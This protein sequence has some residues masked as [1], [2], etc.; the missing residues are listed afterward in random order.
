[1]TTFRT[2]ITAD[3][4][5]RPSPIAYQHKIL[6]LG[7]C[8]AENIGAKLANLYFQQCLN[9]FGISYNPASIAQNLRRLA[10]NRIFEPSELFEEND[11]FQSFAHHSS[12][13]ADSSQKAL[14]K[15]N[16]AYRRGASYYDDA[17]Y[18]IITLGTAWIYKLIGNQQIVNNCHRQKA[19]IFERSRLTVAQIVDN[20][21]PIFAASPRRQIILT[22]S[23]VRHLKDTLHGNQI[24]KSLLLLACE[25]LCE[26]LPTQVFYF[27]AYEIMMDDL[28]DY[29][30]Y[31]DD[32]QHPSGMAVDYIWSFFEAHYLA[33]S[34]KSWRRQIGDLQKAAQHRPF[35]L[36]TD[37]HQ[38]FL[39]TQIEK[40]AK[41][42]KDLPQLN[43]DAL[44][45]IFQ[46]Q[47]I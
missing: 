5:G 28:R 13:G 30:F 8:F 42:E 22:V 3:Q 21:Y 38:Q 10:E 2:N 41:L 25:Q 31:A 7:S 35:N 34:E 47:M 26:L 19:N 15:I 23:P 11:L 14:Q 36:Q 12:F 43:F 4:L 6:T 46:Q 27:P 40:I 39:Q 16:A 17:D 18:L 29:R 45:H 32:M 24:S 44:R 20:L 37:T 9:P 33:E 1:M